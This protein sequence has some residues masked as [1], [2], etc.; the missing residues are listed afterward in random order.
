[1]NKSFIERG[2][3]THRQATRAWKLA[4]RPVSPPLSSATILPDFLREARVHA[5]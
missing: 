2:R 5:G 3:V 1:M 4:Q